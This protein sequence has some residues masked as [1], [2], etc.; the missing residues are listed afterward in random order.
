MLRGDMYLGRAL[1]KTEFRVSRIIA[2]VLVG[3]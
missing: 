2:V 1:L 3:L